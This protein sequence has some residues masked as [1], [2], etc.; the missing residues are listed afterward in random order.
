MGQLAAGESELLAEISVSTDRM[1]KP[2]VSEVDSVMEREWGGKRQLHSSQELPGQQR[3]PLHVPITASILAYCEQQ[4]LYTDPSSQRNTIASLPMM[5]LT[6][7]VEMLDLLP[8]G[9]LLGSPLV[10][11]AHSQVGYCFTLVTVL[12]R[13]AKLYKVVHCW[14][15][16]DRP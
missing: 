14:E 3:L 1:L 4:D 9:V 10:Q 6:Q 13:S 16:F 11:Q 15:H 2:N 12:K 7:Q 8:G 5:M